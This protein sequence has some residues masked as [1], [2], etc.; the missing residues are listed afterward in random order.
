MARR[1]HAPAAL[2]LPAGGPGLHRQVILL[3]P[4]GFDLDVFEGCPHLYRGR[5]QRRLAAPESL[6]QAE[7]P[8]PSAAQGAQPY[9]LVVAEELAH[10]WH[11]ENLRDRLQVIVRDGQARG[12][13]IIA[14]SQ[15]VPSKS[16]FSF[17]YAAFFNS[18]SEYGLPNRYGDVL[19]QLR[20]DLR[21]GRFF[22][23]LL[24]ERVGLHDLA[25]LGWGH[26]LT[27]PYVS[28]EVVQQV[29]SEQAA[30]W[31]GAGAAARGHKDPRETHS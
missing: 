27:A 2:P 23:A 14:V 3:D 8:I 29:L 10:L 21:P 6:A 26:L 22:L 16:S 30:W 20:R 28:R 11:A 31:A 4:S 15:A 12:V 25:D 17:P 19:R 13:G 9:Y 1:L 18:Q 24:D 5:T 7:V